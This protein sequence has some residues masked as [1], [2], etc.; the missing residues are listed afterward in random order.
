MG[1]DVTTEDDIESMR[2]IIENTKMVRY[3]IM[4]QL[5]TQDI[6]AKPNPLGVDLSVLSAT[7]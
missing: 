2:T 4:S 7:L 6:D 5:D 1:T 3:S